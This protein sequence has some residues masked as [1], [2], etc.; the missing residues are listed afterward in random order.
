[1]IGTVFPHSTHVIENQQGDDV[2]LFRRPGRS[3]HSVNFRR[4]F[5]SFLLI[6]L[7]PMV[8]ATS[9]YSFS[10]AKLRNTVRET[11]QANIQMMAL[12]LD[13]QF[14]VMNNIVEQVFGNTDFQTL[15]AQSFP[16]DS[17][18]KLTASEIQQQ[19][20]SYL[21]ASPSI[22]DIFIYFPNSDM[23]LSKRVFYRLENTDRISQLSFGMDTDELRQLMTSP[24]YGELVITNQ[25][26]TRH[27]Y[28]LCSSSAPALQNTFSIMLDINLSRFY[29]LLHAAGPDSFILLP[30]G[31]LIFDTVSSST[32]LAQQLTENLSESSGFLKPLNRYL[33]RQDS[34]IL[35]GVAF[36]RLI[37]STE[38]NAPLKGVWVMIIVYFIATLS[39]GSVF[40]FKLARRNYAGIEQLVQK[41]HQVAGQ[42][43]PGSDDFQYIQQI[44]GQLL[45]ERNEYNRLQIER[46]N[47]SCNGILGR[48]LKGRQYSLE[49]FWRECEAAGEPLPKEQHFILCVLRI[50]DGVNLFFEQRRELENWMIDTIFMMTGNILQELI[51]NA[52]FT[53]FIHETDGIQAA[54][55][56]V[57]DGG[58]TYFQQ[59]GSKLQEAGN[60]VCRI[61]KEDFAVQISIIISGAETG[62]VGI[63]EA[64]ERMLG[65]MTLRD[66]REGEYPPVTLLKGRPNSPHRM[67]IRKSIEQIHTGDYAGAKETLESLCESA[68]KPQ[69]TPEASGCGRRQLVEEVCKYIDQ[70]CLQAT[71]SLGEVSEYFHISSSY[72]SQIFKK[73]L[74][75]SPLDYVQK[76]RLT[77]AKQQLDKGA[78][79]RDAAIA[80]GYYD[81]RPMIRAFR[82]YEGITPSEYRSGTNT[83]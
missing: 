12:Q 34:E 46:K 3:T 1:M 51:K 31:D 26:N 8:L 64:Y 19:I 67:L 7:L 25:G 57:P 20:L 36:L 9:V 5:Y 32:S 18:Q 54:L 29:Q 76:K 66:L 22:N 71:F 49:Q 50:D 78:S 81:T 80:A 55:V 37:A 73:E 63:A 23:L 58:E 6:L 61:M 74:G 47:A 59:I 16:Y 75:Y 72:L 45:E 28:Y 30:E 13:Q 68:V 24:R 42:S 56:P 69:P 52:G 70:K 60:T 4:L 15:A 65:M 44:I 77:V 83:D 39:L 40:T 38:Y 43:K 48:V 53:P 14:N 27:L 21:T 17:Y 82:R 62:L 35:N 79:V 10:L 11:N 41:L 2:L 33:I